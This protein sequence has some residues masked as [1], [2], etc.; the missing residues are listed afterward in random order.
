MWTSAELKERAKIALK[1]NYWKAFAISLI[2]IV[3]SGGGSG[4]SS[5]RYTSDGGFQNVEPEMILLIIAIALV[6]IA[7]AVAFQTFV[8]GPLEVGVKR[9]FTSQAESVDTGEVPA[10]NLIGHGFKSGKYMEVVK[11]Q[12]M[13]NLYIFLWSLLLIIPGIIKSYSYAMV[14]YLLADNPGLGVKRAIELSKE[15]TNGEKMDMFILDLSFL[16]W[17]LL[18]FIACCVGIVFVYPYY[19]AT[20]AELYRV[21]REK[22]LESDLCSYE[23]LGFVPPSDITEETSVEEDRYDF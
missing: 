15:M 23:E 14:P 10:F 11:T 7:F 9:Y 12:F 16:G 3:A 18:G 6:V 19:Y 4:S 8:T 13:K 21:L 5:S 22:G 2:L 20:H 1:G 17:W